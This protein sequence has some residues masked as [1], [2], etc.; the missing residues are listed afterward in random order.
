MLTLHPMPSNYSIQSLTRLKTI[1]VETPYRF[2]E[3]KIQQL[4]DYFF[5]RPAGSKITSLSDSISILTLHP[6]P[7]NYLNKSLT[8]LKNNIC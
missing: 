3:L 7:P 1:Y 4:I 5:H 6:M 8:R 2:F